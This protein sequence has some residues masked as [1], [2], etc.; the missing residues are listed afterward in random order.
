MLFIIP[1]VFLDLLQAFKL[2][3]TGIEIIFDAHKKLFSR[4]SKIFFMRMKINF[5]AHENIKATRTV[6]RKML[7]CVQIRHG[8]LVRGSVFLP[9]TGGLV[10]FNK[11]L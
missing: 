8:Y 2:M 1:K 5:D 7:L 10:W 4:A 6:E 11:R 3:I 9:K